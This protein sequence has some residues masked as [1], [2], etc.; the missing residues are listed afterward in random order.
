MELNTIIHGF[1]LMEEKKV[2]E[3]NS[4]ARIFLHEKSGAKLLNLENDD[5]NKVFAITFRTPPSDS[6]GLPHILEHSVL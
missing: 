4:T 1:K 5:E 2:K 3:L 6:T